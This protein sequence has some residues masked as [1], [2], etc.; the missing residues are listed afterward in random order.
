MTLDNN[1]DWLQKNVVVCLGALVCCGL[2]GSAFPSIKIGYQLFDIAAND[3]ATQMLFAGVRFTLAGI[4][5]IILGSIIA[6]KTLVPEKSSWKLIVK[7]CMV[8]TVIQ[9]VFFY[10]GLANTTG[11]KAS[12]IEAMNVFIAIIMASL[13][14]KEKITGLKAVGCAIG[15]IG[16][17]LINITKDGIDANLSLIGEGFLLFSTVAYA[18]SQILIKK[19]SKYEN[20]VTLSG[21]QFFIGG[22]IMAVTGFAMGGRLTVVTGQGLIMLLYLACISAVAYSLWGILLKHNPVSKVAIYG[23]TNPVFG[24][25]L[26]AMFLEGES[27]QAFGI[28][29]IVSLVL[30]CIG[31]YLT[32]IV[33]KEK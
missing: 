14:F 26:S 30:V 25:L 1:K 33:Q 22:L 31:I 27:S 32:N 24:V 8:Q 7:L 13:F 5:T 10:I 17:V 23:F 4:L 19:Y 18:L 12:I 29:G 11:V 21:Y 6:R 9:Y 16:V 2:W 28:K 3:T 20:P 15:F